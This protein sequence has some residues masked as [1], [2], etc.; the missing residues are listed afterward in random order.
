M[1]APTF[2][3]KTICIM[4]LVL[5]LAAATTVAGAVLPE[6]YV[7]EAPIARSD[8]IDSAAQLEALDQVL[9]RLTGVRGLREQLNIG[10]AQLG[11]LIQSRQVIERERVNAEGERERVL[12]ERIEFDAPSIDE[13]LAE[14]G[15]ARWGRERPTVLVWAVTEQ[16][17]EAIWLQDPAV[18][19]FLRELGRIHGLD[20][21]RPLGDAMDLADLS[22]AD[23]RG[24]FL[25]QLEPG[26]DRYGASVGVM[27]DLR[28][29]E[30][31]FLARAFWRIDGVDGGQAFL[32]ESKTDVLSATFQALHRIM[33]RRYAI[34][35]NDQDT[36]TQR[37][38]LI[39]MTDPVQYAEALGYLR[40]LGVIESIRLVRASGSDLEFEVVSKGD[41][42]VDVLALGH[43]LEVVRAERSGPVELR[44]Q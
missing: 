36:R 5:G 41:N 24:G 20:L 42:L 40:T 8:G 16:D 27:L 37:I 17:F 11:Q 12:A 19:G 22:L 29:D 15:I 28:P 14:Q 39:E 38:R 31:G 25:D 34:D 23:V 18:D 1:K 3:K 26:L 43:I 7:G 10:Q 30:E 21:I 6:L 4:T 44:L 32:G 2:L 13:L 33:A 9:T 35:L